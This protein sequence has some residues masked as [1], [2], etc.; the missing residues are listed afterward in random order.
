MA[1]RAIQSEA[2]VIL[3]D[4]RAILSEAKELFLSPTVSSG[5]ALLNDKVGFFGL[6]FFGMTGK[7]M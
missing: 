5:F 7:G 4:S 1:Q 3:S 6:R 2:V